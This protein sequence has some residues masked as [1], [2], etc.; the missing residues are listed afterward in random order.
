MSDKE[1]IKA[2]LKEAS[3]YTNQGLFVEAKQKYLKVLEAIKNSKHYR[4]DAKLLGALQIKIKELERK[5]EETLQ[6]DQ[7]PALTPEVQ[8]LILRLFAFSRNK[9]MA[10]I[11]GA[12]ALA[13]FGQYEKAMAEFKRLMKQGVMPLIAAKNILRCHQNLSSINGAITE[14]E[15]WVSEGALSPEHLMNLRAFLLEILDKGL[16]HG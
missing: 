3:L 7:P 8:E 1:K 14:F 4:G 5:R 6:D 2:L 13:K 9:G 11:E 10:A 15:Q 12:V 16:G